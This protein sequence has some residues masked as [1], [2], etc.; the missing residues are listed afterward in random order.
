M[1]ASGSEQTGEGLKGDDPSGTVACDTLIGLPA[2]SPDW[3]E[4]R[5]FDLTMFTDK[6]PEPKGSEPSVLT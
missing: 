3:G 6:L 5:S 1:D 2:T 4:E